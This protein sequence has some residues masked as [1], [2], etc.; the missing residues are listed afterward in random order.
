[1]ITCVCRAMPLAVNKAFCHGFD[2]V[3][4]ASPERKRCAQS[5]RRKEH[6][7]VSECFLFRNPAWGASDVIRQNQEEH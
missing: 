1:M 4:A 2:S 3:P 6:T 7:D 5:E